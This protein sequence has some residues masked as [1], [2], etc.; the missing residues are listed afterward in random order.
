MTPEP[1]SVLASRIIRAHDNPSPPPWAPNLLAMG[2]ASTSASPTPPLALSPH[3]E[4]ASRDPSGSRSKSSTPTTR[5]RLAER[6]TTSAV[7]T[8]DLISFDSFSTS[9][10]TFRYVIT[11]PGPTAQPSDTPIIDD[12]FTRSPSLAPPAV[13]AALSIPLVTLDSPRGG[14]NEALG[15]RFEM[16]PE[17]IDE[18]S[19]LR[20]LLSDTDESYRG[21]PKP[22]SPSV[23]ETILLQ[24]IP[25]PAENQTDASIQLSG[26]LHYTDDGA[27]LNGESE[28]LPL[29]DSSDA[30]IRKKKKR[31]G[32]R[33]EVSMEVEI[34]S[35][36]EAGSSQAEDNNKITLTDTG[37]ATQEGGTR[38]RDRDILKTPTRTDYR[39]LGSLSPT[40]TNLLT[41]LLPSPTRGTTPIIDPEAHSSAG[42]IVAQTPASFES[43]RPLPLFPQI[44]QP[45]LP[46]TPIRSTSPVRFSSPVRANPLHSP[47]K[48]RL[49]PAALDDPNRTPA[50][51]IPIDEAVT[52]GHISPQKAARL[53][54]DVGRTPVFNIRPTDSPARR[55]YITEAPTPSGQ[56]KWQGIRFGSPSRSVSRQRSASIEP[57]PLVP[58]SGKASDRVSSS[59][60]PLH[61]KDASIARP[62]TI[63]SSSGT[64]ITTHRLAKLPFPIV[65]SRPQI[66]SSISEEF[67]G[68][69]EVPEAQ[70]SSPVKPPAPSS[71]PV[72]SGL[73]QTTS[74][75]PRGV[76][77]YARPPLSKPANKEKSKH[78]MMRTVE[79]PKP[80]ES[81]R[82]VL[83]RCNTCF[84]NNRF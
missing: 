34:V 71:S 77:P 59:Q 30:E 42:A 21:S 49:Q 69:R 58:F 67:E 57:L 66:P 12:L 45:P 8:P 16:T 5:S 7:V 51:R 36:S 48:P 27:T 22:E 24:Q 81:A 68:E 80:G 47:G 26:Y 84:F 60:R 31:E 38:K 9:K 20:T 4:V 1:S 74:K 83:V 46:R 39:E 14:N 76:K 54:A 73:K 61:L 79:L 35:D 28:A 2:D 75:I 33:R 25:N 13:D 62:Q 41:Q 78:T 43:F 10:D 64:S 72:K 37:G 52:Q 17:S 18:Q 32:K 70:M 63:G 3:P 56:K 29:I 44:S 65:A 53:T 23:P 82:V 15:G 6:P 40:S 50:R 55:V 19:V 11:E